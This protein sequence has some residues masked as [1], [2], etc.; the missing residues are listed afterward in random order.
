VYYSKR[1]SA[2]LGGITTYDTGTVAGMES[3]D[4]PFRR[5][6]ECPAGGVTGF[7]NCIGAAV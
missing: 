4:R 2:Q 5:D 1:I 3:D 6:V 7:G